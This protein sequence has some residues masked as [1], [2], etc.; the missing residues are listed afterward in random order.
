LA[1]EFHEWQNLGPAFQAMRANAPIL[2]DCDDR[3][4]TLGQLGAAGLEALTYLQ[5]GTT[6][7][8]EWKDATLKLINDAEKP[9]KSMLKLSWLPSYR[10]LVLAAANVDALKTSSPQ[11]WKQQVFDEAA[12]QEPGAKYTW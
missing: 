4:Q 10:A 11:Q 3:V 8:A 2:A 9:D 7:P 5:N 6:P 1:Q 12:K